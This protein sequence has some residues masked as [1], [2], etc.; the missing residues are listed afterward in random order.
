MG[1]GLVPAGGTVVFAVAPEGWADAGV[2]FGALEGAFKV[3]FV[4]GDVH[5]HLGKFTMIPIQKFLKIW[6]SL[7]SVFQ[8]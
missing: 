2:Q 4:D 3:G 1:F 8:V 7:Y 6:A 5:W